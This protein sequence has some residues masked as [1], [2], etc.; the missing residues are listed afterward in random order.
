MPEKKSHIVQGFQVCRM[1]LRLG[2]QDGEIFFHVVNPSFN[3][4][5]EGL[6]H[7]SRLLRVDVQVSAHATIK[8][9]FC[10]QY[11]HLIT[12]VDI[13]DKI[14]H[15]Y[16]HSACVYMSGLQDGVLQGVLIIIN[17]TAA[18]TLSDL[19]LLAKT[20]GLILLERL[21]RIPNNHQ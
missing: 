10:R 8:H 4:N 16:A 15:K 18:D 1:I 20:Y 2:G 13:L 17:L 21:G 6:E 5:F 14:L 12:F 19:S 9:T 7:A 3:R 11:F